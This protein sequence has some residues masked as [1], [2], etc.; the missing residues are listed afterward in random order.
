[1]IQHT[2]T[3]HSRLFWCIILISISHFVFTLFFND[4]VTVN[5]ISVLAVGAVAIFSYN[6]SKKY[7]GTTIRYFLISLSLGYASY[8]ISEVSWLYFSIINKNVPVPSPIDI[9]YGIF[10]IAFTASIFINL[11]KFGY[12]KY[13]IRE[14]FIRTKILK[15]L[16][17]AVI[18]MTI[19][20]SLFTIL[21]YYEKFS[22]NQYIFSVFFLSWT[23]LLIAFTGNVLYQVRYNNLFSP[24]KW[25]LIG[26]VLQEAG[27]ILYYAYD[28]WVKYDYQSWE[29][30]LWL[31]GN[32]LMLYGIMIYKKEI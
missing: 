15:I 6:L 31:A 18:S 23:A 24:W 1:M 29:N 11:M 2:T 32:L 17:I 19:T 4:G 26:M 13:T 22:S 3:K 16:F 8:F 25:F 27:D 30:S 5:L 21:S 28:V 7:R 20:L 12:A 9:F 14:H 10:F